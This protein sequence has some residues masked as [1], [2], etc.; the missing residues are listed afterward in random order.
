MVDELRKSKEELNANLLTFEQDIL[1]DV[2]SWIPYHLSSSRVFF[3]H[4]ATRLVVTL[5]VLHVTTALGIVSVFYSYV[6]LKYPLPK[7]VYHSVLTTNW[8]RYKPRIVSY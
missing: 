1:L 7:I 8:Y 4:E 3:Y 5:L 2:T 6:H